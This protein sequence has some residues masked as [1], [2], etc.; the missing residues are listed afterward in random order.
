MD[1]PD[2]RQH[3]QRAVA[4]ER[5]LDKPIERIA[6]ASDASFYRLVPRAVVLPANVE[7]VAALFRVSQDLRV[8]LTF[9][10]AGT[11][12]S[13]QAVTDGILVDVSRH[14]RALEVQD[15][16]RRVR[17][18]PGVIG[19]HVNRALKPYGRKMGP[20]P[21]SIATCQLGGILSNNASG[22]CCGVAQ[23]AFH[24]LHS[25]RF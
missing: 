22:M 7:E 6:H 25:T 10:A 20:D 14:F 23:N 5:I 21:A 4:G 19:A 16:G 8:P 11:S 2:L 24:T 18:E 9:R 1:L 15:G 3:L 12:L 13:G 17:V